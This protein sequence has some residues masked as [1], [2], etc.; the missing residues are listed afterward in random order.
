MLAVEG[1][2]QDNQLMLNEKVSFSKPVKVVVTFLD[3][4]QLDEFQ[5]IDLAQFS[6]AQSRAILRELKSSLSD[7]LVAERRNAA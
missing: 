6:F 4:P 5:R 7:V 2:Y 1:I 3:E